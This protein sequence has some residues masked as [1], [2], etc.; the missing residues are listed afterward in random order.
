MLCCCVCMQ[1]LKAD[2]LLESE[3]KLFI[4]FFTNPSQLG[5]VLGNLAKRID[6]I[7]LAS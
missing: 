7:T 5:Q 3:K 4:H 6:S 2:P 1:L